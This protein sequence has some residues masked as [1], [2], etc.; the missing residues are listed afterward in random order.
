MPHAGISWLLAPEFWLLF[1]CLAP[2]TLCLL[3]NKKGALFENIRERPLRLKS[4]Y[5]LFSI[6]IVF[7]LTLL[8]V[9]LALAKLFFHFGHLSEFVVHLLK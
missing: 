7:F 1:L 9:I 6:F 4:H 2:C 5:Y 3:L 8:F